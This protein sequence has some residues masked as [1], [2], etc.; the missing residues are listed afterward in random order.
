MRPL[1][2]QAFVDAFG[3]VRQ[4]LLQGDCDAAGNAAS[5]VFVVAGAAVGMAEV[6]WPV[7]GAGRRRSSGAVVEA[8]VGL[9]GRHA[10]NPWRRMRSM[11]AAV[12]SSSR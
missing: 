1:G 6:K 4:A 2:L 12:S 10:G 7:R 5:S 11:K 9:P 3:A 8:V